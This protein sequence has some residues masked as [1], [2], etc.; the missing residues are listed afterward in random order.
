MEVSNMRVIKTYNLRSDIVD[1]LNKEVRRRYRSKWVQEAIEEKLN[2][3]ANFDLHEFKTSE[4]V[5]H[6]RNTRFTSLTDLE[7]TLLDELAD[8][9][10]EKGD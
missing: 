5:L 2:R 8:R 1:E 10:F 6:I 4:L 7:K 3:K 9:L